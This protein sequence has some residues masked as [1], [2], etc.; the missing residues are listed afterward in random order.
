[1]RSYTTYQCTVCDN[2]VN[3][4]PKTNYTHCT[5]CNTV[6]YKSKEDKLESKLI[7][8]ISKT[9]SPIQ[10]GTTGVYDNQKFEVIGRCKLSFE[11]EIVSLFT[12]AFEHDDIGM[13]TSSM[14]VYAI[15]KFHDLSEQQKKAVNG[16]VL[17]KQSSIEFNNVTC[18]CTNTQKTNQ[19]E[20][21]G[22]CYFP[23]IFSDTNYYTFN[24]NVNTKLVVLKGKDEVTT[25]LQESFVAINELQLKNLKTPNPI[26]IACTICNNQLKIY[27]ID[28]TKVINCNKCNSNFLY[29]NYELKQQG[30]NET[31][32]LKIYFDIED[33]LEFYNAKYKIIGICVKQDFTIY[34]SKWREYCLYNPTEG[35]LF[36][37]E[38]DG[39]WIIVNR[40]YSNRD[41]QE[42]YE[43]IEFDNKQY[44]LY[45]K[46]SYKTIYI[47][48]C[49]PYKLFYNKQLTCLEY[50]A[51]PVMVIKEKQDNNINWFAATHVNKKELQKQSKK[52]LPYKVGIG[53]IEDKGQVQTKT[54]FW[55]ALYC[56]L[57]TGIVQYLTTF[58]KSNQ[59]IVNQNYD[60]PDSVNTVL[61]SIN[62]V[63]LNQSSSNLNIEVSAAVSNAWFELNIEAINNKTGERFYAEQG[64]EFYSGYDSGEYWKEGTTV[65]DV[66]ISKIPKGNY[67]IN[68]TALQE[69]STNKANY[70]N[71]AIVYD[72]PIYKNFFLVFFGILLLAVL[73]YARSYYIN[74]RRWQNSPYYEIKFP[75]TTN[76]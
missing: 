70:F 42:E 27:D 67:T 62:D 66:T 31:K 51:P 46:Y 22:N 24:Y 34:K 43:I 72:T 49:F 60:F 65:D 8:P 15:G 41:T 7:N 52:S 36:L 33:E 11:S 9:S 48:G 6:L 17:V 1:M 45:N 23:N 3:F 50:I 28:N 40:L 5:K 14:G 47:E 19:I 25:L 61:Y 44:E 76:E 20:I 12:I 30:K 57:L 39:H 26:H 10:I 73:A 18:E 58:N 4:H 2:A 21:E 75:S 69:A 55:V 16:I 56:L 71:V 37:N 29:D 35:Y 53:A 64:L 54:I 13:L 63:A 74:I 68:L 32:S 38:F 59:T